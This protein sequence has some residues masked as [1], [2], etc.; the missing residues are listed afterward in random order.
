[1]SPNEVDSKIQ[2]LESRLDKAEALLDAA[3]RVLETI[4]RV[5][6][7]AGR[8]RRTQFVLVAGSALIVV[9]VVV[10]ARRQNSH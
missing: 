2:R 4:E 10:S 5:H 1:M 7:H 3:G 6:D 8:R 9:S